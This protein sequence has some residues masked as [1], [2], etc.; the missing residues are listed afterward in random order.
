MRLFSLFLLLAFLLLSSCKDKVICDENTPVTRSMDSMED[1]LNYILGMSLASQFSY[2][3]END[4]RPDMIQLAVQDFINGKDFR[5]EDE[6]KNEIVKEY[7]R[8]ARTF[9]D[10]SMRNESIR[11]LKA[12]GKKDGVITAD[13]GLQYKYLKKG[14][15]GGISPDG[16][17]VVY[18]NYIQGSAQRGQLWDQ[19]MATNKRDTISMALNRELTGFSQMCQ[20]MKVGD[21]VKAWLPPT[22]GSAEGRDPAG[23]AQKNEV[24]WIEMELL[25]VDERKTSQ[26]TGGELSGYPGYFINEEERND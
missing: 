5:I 1:S 11:F 17:D 3:N 23:V 2:Y 8:W 10:D 6:A 7:F 15:E 18:L 26:I 25:K 21:K 24:I 16:N 12:N 4:F 20:L 19:S 9:K 13:R 14:P 22:I